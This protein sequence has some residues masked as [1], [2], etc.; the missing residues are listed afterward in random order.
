MPSL[1]S[2]KFQSLDVAKV[3]SGSP[4]LSVSQPLFSLGSGWKDGGC[5]MQKPF[6]PGGLG[7]DK[8]GGLSSV[9]ATRCINYSHSRVAMVRGNFWKM[10]KLN[11][12][13]TIPKNRVSGSS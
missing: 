8:G 7:W 1:E 9:Q 12:K 5:M 10:L 11:S 13:R 3:P 6:L 4:F 2:G